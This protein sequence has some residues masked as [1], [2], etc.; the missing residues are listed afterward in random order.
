[1]NWSIK[2]KF[3]LKK[4]IIMENENLTISEVSVLLS[5]ILKKQN[6][7]GAQIQRMME[8]LENAPK[9]EPV[10][11]WLTIDGLCAYLPEHPAKGT[12]YQW[13]FKYYKEGG[14]LRF[15]K[16]DID[17]WLKSGRHATQKELMAEVAEMLHAKSRGNELL[18]D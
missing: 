14:N 18:H 13:V 1:L 10:N 15:L 8:L 4:I 12:I 6:E 7:Q 17:E 3:N 2:T 11:E 16:S 9:G 5:Q